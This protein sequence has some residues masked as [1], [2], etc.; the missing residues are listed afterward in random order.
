VTELLASR[1]ALLFAGLIAAPLGAHDL[2]IE[3]SSFQPPSG[4]AVALH[5][6]VGE[7]F[8]GEPVP[9][10]PQR[11]ERFAVVAPDGA[12]IPA[13][14]E[15]GAD[16][17][18]M[19]LLAAPGLHIAVYRSNQ[20]FIE[21][22]AAKFEAYLREEGLEP[23]IE[24]RRRR[25]ERAAPGRELYSRS[26]KSLLAVGGAGGRDSPLGLPLELIVESDARAL[27]QGEALAVR[28]LFR[29]RPLP[30]AQVVAMPR[31]SP[32]GRVVRRTDAAGRA[33]FPLPRT[34]PWL[35]KAVHVVRLDA[36]PR[37]DWESFWASLTFARRRR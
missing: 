7:G 2:W 13:T 4:A 28:L 35:V 11:I 15:P 33:T 6:R 21:L 9:R 22:E 31:E 1:S 29:G 17:A 36:D 20:A 26:V 37:A 25:G 19:V 8:A 14:G 5:L 12:E 23:V 32:E 16:P 24:E 34:G 30:G 3:P 27:D 10:N 18:G